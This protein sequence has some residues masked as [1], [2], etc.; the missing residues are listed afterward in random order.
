MKQKIYL[1]NKVFIA[2]GLIESETEA[3]ATEQERDKAWNKLLHSHNNMIIE[4]F[5]LDLNH[6][7]IDYVYDWDDEELEFYCSDDPD[8]HHDYFTKDETTIEVQNETC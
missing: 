1:I 8:M 4:C 7:P 6:I 5:N 2:D 3:F